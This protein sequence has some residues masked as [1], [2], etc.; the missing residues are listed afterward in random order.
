MF[1]LSKSCCLGREWPA[2]HLLGGPNVSRVCLRFW[3]VFSEIQTIFSGK[4]A[5]FNRPLRSKQFS[6]SSLLLS[7]RV[8]LKYESH[9]LLFSQKIPLD[10]IVPLSILNSCLFSPQCSRSFS[11]SR[12]AH[13]HQHCFGISSP[14]SPYL[15]T[16]TPHFI[17]LARM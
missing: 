16:S 5:V 2:S 11:S 12:Q 6:S 17:L 7:D 1:P 4:A 8:G 14:C 13:L 3:T 15:L 9:L 10:I